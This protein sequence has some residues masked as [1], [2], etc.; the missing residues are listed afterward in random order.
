LNCLYIAKDQYE[1][2]KFRHIDYLK[3]TDLL[4]INSDSKLLQKQIEELKEKSTAREYVIKG[5]LQEKDEQIHG[6]VKKQ[7]KFEQLI[8]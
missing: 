3:A 5:K 2:L 1:P 8:Q 7:E 4:T 6:L